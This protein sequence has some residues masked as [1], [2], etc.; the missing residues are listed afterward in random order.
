MYKAKTSN[1]YI[2]QFFF[3]KYMWLVWSSASCVVVLASYIPALLS[4]AVFH[5]AL[6]DSKPHCQSGIMAVEEGNFSYLRLTRVR[7]CL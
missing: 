3:V 7:L 4:I 5:S 6:Q 2:K 1:L